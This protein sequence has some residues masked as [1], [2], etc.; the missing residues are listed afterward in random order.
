MYIAV[1]GGANAPSARRVFP[2]VVSLRT[3]GVLLRED[4]TLGTRPSRTVENREGWQPP[5]VEN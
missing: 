2:L 4:A 3:K 1:I 5:G